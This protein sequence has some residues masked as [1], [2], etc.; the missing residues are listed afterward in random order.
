MLGKPVAAQAVPR[1]SWHASASM[2]KLAA[3]PDSRG[4]KIE[5]MPSDMADIV[6]ALW[7]ERCKA[8]VSVSGYLIGNQQ[9]GKVPLPPSAE[10]Q[11]W[12]QYYFATARGRAGCWP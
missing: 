11:W 1:E 10:L 6:A 9:A 3:V 5:E 7:S 8:L 2:D 4:P 12:D